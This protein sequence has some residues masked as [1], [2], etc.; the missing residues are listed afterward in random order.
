MVPAFLLHVRLT[1]NMLL[2]IG[3]TFSCEI[4]V[5]I[6]ACENKLLN[7]LMLELERNE[8]LDPRIVQNI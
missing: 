8:S 3:D 1:V 7:K 5:K 4:E 6:C 2:P